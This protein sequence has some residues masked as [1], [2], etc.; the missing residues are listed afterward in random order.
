VLRDYTH[1][2]SAIS[3][4]GGRN[5]TFDLGGNDLEIY[6]E[7]TAPTPGF[8][9]ALSVSGDAVI[10]ITGSGE[11]S[12]TSHRNHGVYV[13]G[14][15]SAATV[16]NA[17]TF[18]DFAA[19]AIAALG[20]TVTVLN[21]ASATGE[22]SFGALAW[23]NSTVTVHGDVTAIGENSFGALAGEGGTATVHGNTIASGLN[24]VGTRAMLGS[25]ITALA[26]VTATGTD[27]IGAW[28]E[29]GTI[30]VYGT[31]S[32]AGSPV[33]LGSPPSPTLRTLAD[34]DRIAGGFMYFEEGTAPNVS[35]V[36]VNSDIT[37][38]AFTIATAN[39]ATAT[40]TTTTL[41]LGFNVVPAAFALANI[42]V[43]VGGVNLT[44]SDLAV[45]TPNS[46]S[47]NIAGDWADGATATVTL[48]NPAGFLITPLTQTVTLHRAVSHNVIWQT[49]GGLPAPTQII[50][51][52]G[53]EISEPA[54][55]TRAGHSF[56]GW[57]T[58]AGFTGTAVTFP[59]ANVT[60]D[61]EFFAL[62]N[63]TH[64]NISWAVTTAPDCTTLGVNTGT[65][66][67]CGHTETQSLPE[68]GHNW[69]GGTPATCTT[70]GFAAGNCLDCGASSAGIGAIPA[71]GHYFPATWTER[72][73]AT[74]ETAGVEYR[75]C[76]RAG[77]THEE[78][79]AVAAL[80]HDMPAS[81]TERIAATCEV[82][83]VEYRIYNASGC[84]HEE[85]QAV[86]ALGHDM[87][88]SWTERTAA[89]CETSG[90]EYRACL[91]IG[92]THEETQAVAALGHTWGVWTVTTAATATQAGEE[93]RECVRYA[94]CG[95]YE[96]REIPA[97]GTGGAPGTPSRP[98]ASRP[99][100]PQQGG[101][102][103]WVH[104]NERANANA[105]DADSDAPGNDGAEEGTIG[106]AE[107]RRLHLLLRLNSYVGV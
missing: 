104:P 68:T 8:I 63:C 92:C 76:L 107:D 83:G 100:P 74:C 52:H 60:A 42:Q 88:A 80:G 69:S 15:N 97:T 84:T 96:T 59:V 27:S 64:A 35:T 16:T 99:R 47:V 61:A 50:V 17:A 77:C 106:E 85:T 36:R 26:S 87:P 89:T 58:T 51:T 43:S 71:L 2:N 105:A 30:T 19:A 18:A 33:A 56:G 95:H 67:D 13:E 1:L 34:F 70:D 46:R 6:I 22:N 9:Y 5:I 10:D 65:C 38:V 78:T 55:M 102:I 66:P 81:W 4:G 11:F 93:R 72:I 24:S 53:G 25:T 21:N 75:V 54:A 57:F 45:V 73:A 86:A 39:G 32:G 44:V 101:F 3:V 14:A 82:A 98:T 49:N 48:T 31:L 7:A 40:E 62:W 90:L 37:P 94:D 79:Q 103:G 28:A 29:D 20:G 91:R 23:E 12:V 41:I